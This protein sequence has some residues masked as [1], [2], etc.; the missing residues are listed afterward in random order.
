[1]KDIQHEAAGIRLQNRQRI[2]AL[3][4]IIKTQRTLLEQHYETQGCDRNTA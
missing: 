1:M 3:N 4:G 2:D